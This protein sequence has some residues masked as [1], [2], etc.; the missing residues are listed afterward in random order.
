M[1]MCEKPGYPNTSIKVTNLHNGLLRVSSDPG[2]K[3]FWVLGQAR[4]D[5]LKIFTLKSGRLTL[6]CGVTWAWSERG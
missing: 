6:S 4:V 1:D 5:E 2:G 3:L